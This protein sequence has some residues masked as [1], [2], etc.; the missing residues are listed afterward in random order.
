MKSVLCLIIFSGA[1]VLFSQ[2]IVLPEERVWGKDLS[3]RK[4]RI[5]PTSPPEFPIWFPEIPALPGPEVPTA[6]TT[7]AAG[8]SE[9]ILAVKGGSFYTGE[10]QFGWTCQEKDFRSDLNLATAYSRGYRA[11]SAFSRQYLGFSFENQKQPLNFSGWFLN[12]IME[13]PGPVSAPLYGSRESQ[14]LCLRTDFVPEKAPL[15][16]SLE[17]K[18]HRIDDLSANY[19]TLGCA[20]KKGDCSWENYLEWSDLIGY[21]SNTG[22]ASGVN[23][24]K[25]ALK[26]G[27]FLKYIQPEGIRLLPSFRLSLSDNWALEG[28]GSYQIPDFWLAAQEDNYREMTTEKLAPAEY[29]AAGVSYQ[30]HARQYSFQGRITQVWWKTLYTWK[31]TDANFFYQPC[32][33]KDVWATELQLCLKKN[34]TGLVQLFLDSKLDF[35]QRAVEYLPEL[36]TACGLM[37]ENASFQGRLAFVYTGKR[38]FPEGTLKGYPTMQVDFS[39]K[40]CKHVWLGLETSNLFSESYQLVPGYPA[41]KRKI[42]AQARILF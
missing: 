15:T 18:Y 10:I 31:D 23:L 28:E 16:F 24:Q 22:L 9:K 39:K 32:P 37:I 7:E 38:R 36:E 42:L 20:W 12:K 21:D 3:I 13:L 34:L 11:H 41:E 1:W 5:S 19:L 8:K 35:Y 26:F 33:E 6:E 27:L 29:Y 30:R 25:E 17:E 40:V 14:S 4:T 2:N